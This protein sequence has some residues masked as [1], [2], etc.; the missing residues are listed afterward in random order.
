[1]TLDDLRA[2]VYFVAVKH[3][4]YA[5][6]GYFPEGAVVLDPFGIVG[7]QPGIRVVRIGRK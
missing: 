7:D 4:E 3:P 6:P 1:M 2:R 5:K